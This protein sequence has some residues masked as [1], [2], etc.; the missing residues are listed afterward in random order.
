VLKKYLFLLFALLLA[1]C[2]T[3]QGNNEGA[4]SV[5]SIS[6]ENATGTADATAA[7][8][9]AA[10][11]ESAPEGALP[12]P[13]HEG[14]T[15]ADIVAEAN[16]QEV[17]FYMW[18]GSDL[19]NG[20]I[21]G[22]V[23]PAVQ[24]RYGISLNMVPV[25][26][27]TEYINKVLGEKEAG[28]NSGGAVDLVWLNGENFRT[29]RQGDLLYGRWSQFL[30][31]S[32]FVNWNDPSVAND[33][34]FPVDGYEAP[35]GKAQFVMIYDSA[36][37]AEP[38]RD[39]AELVAWIK[40]NPGQFTYPA[41]PDFTGSA[42]VRHICYYTAGGYESMLGEFDETVFDENSAACW[43]L[44]NELEPFLWR[45]GQTYPENHTRQ[46]DLFANGEVSFDMAY[47]PAEASSLVENGRYP[48][49]TRTFVFD[50]GTIANTH[51][52]AIPYN[53]DHKAAAMVVAN[54][55]LSPEA[56]LS[57]AQPANWGDLPVLDPALLPAEWQDR[58]AAVPRG[59]ATLSTEELAAHRLP[60]LQAPWLTAFEQ[61][62]QAEVLQK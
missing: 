23:A 51:Y 59:D 11:V 35:Y 46:Q 6:Q 29:M 20:W 61:G 16:G 7:G 40:A 2:A 53:S 9:D 31:S 37:V 39:V 3:D 5:Q 49:S 36:R 56:Q 18:G 21:T 50:S 52:V 34:G 17:N 33:F 43:G 8:D 19:I 4:G 45:G 55:L 58:F 14:K 38:P 10:A 27:A 13:G 28:R 54:F 47:N 30:P 42:F 62:W 60:E 22:Y 15:W 24:E 44:L 26:D 12:P 25:S 48:E 32:A 1:A 41:P 57:K